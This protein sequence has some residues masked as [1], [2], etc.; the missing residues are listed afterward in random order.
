MVEYCSRLQKAHWITVVEGEGILELCFTVTCIC[1]VLLQKFFQHFLSG[2]LQGQQINSTAFYKP[3][4]LD[5]HED[6]VK[7]RVLKLAREAGITL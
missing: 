6:G 1:C 5:I 3:A 4:Y 2:N 7:R